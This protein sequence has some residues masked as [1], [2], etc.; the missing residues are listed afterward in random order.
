MLGFVAGFYEYD[1]QESERQ[2]RLA[3]ARDPVPPSVRANYAVFYLF[4]IGRT[5]EAVQQVE[6]ALQEDPLNI[7]TR[8]FLA[9]C[10]VGAGRDEDSANELRKVLELNPAVAIAYG[11]LSLHR[12]VQGKLEEALPLAE[13]AYAL[14]PFVP[15]PI[16]ALAGLLKRTGDAGRAEELLQ[17]LQ[18]GDAFG[19]PRGL[20]AFHWMCGEMEATADW[21]DK[22]IDQRDPFI[23][24]SLRLW[25]GRELRS[26]HRWPVWMRKMNLPEG[27]P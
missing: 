2:F 22:A 1:W 7:G 12:V 24:W 23:L 20:A 8:I 27:A 13:K 3:M 19:A 17:K 10:L 6:R 26:S 16:G 15:N 18:P 11:L 4:S 25:Y 14:A 5:V 9:L 21:V